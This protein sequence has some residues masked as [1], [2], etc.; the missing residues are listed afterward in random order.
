MALPLSILGR[1]LGP[2]LLLLV[3][4][5]IWKK[6]FYMRGLTYRATV[7]PF[8]REKIMKS[9]F[10]LGLL[11]SVDA[12]LRR[13]GQLLM[14][15]KLPIFPKS[16][17]SAFLLRLLLLHVP[18]A[19]WAIRGPLSERG[20]TRDDRGWSDAVTRSRF[21]RLVSA[22]FGHAHIVLSEEWRQLSPEEI[23]RWIDR[24][25]AC[26]SAY[27][28][29]SPVIWFGWQGSHSVDKKSSHLG[30]TTIWE[31]V[32]SDIFGPEQFSDAKADS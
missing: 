27:P 21:W 23:R 11:G 32:T 30:C 12:A 8:A 3:T 6:H 4:A 26:S 20:S 31:T 9:I 14:L 10:Y 24:H 7:V 22:A 29:Q 2:L 25:Y 5:F 17:R 18:F 28:T 16:E 15:F 1:D 13:I 19:V